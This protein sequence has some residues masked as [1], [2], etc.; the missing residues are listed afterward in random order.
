MKFAALNQK[1]L[2]DLWHVRGQA[3]AISLVLACGVGTYV[4][5]SGMLQS[6]IDTRQ[7]YYNDYRLADI[8]ATVKRAPNSILAKIRA[9]DGVRQV[10]G[11]VR[12]PGIVDLATVSAPISAQLLSI[13]TLNEQ[14]LN[15]IVLRQGRM[16]NARRSQEI[17]LL[18]AFAEAHKLQPGDALNVVLNGRKKRFEI[19]GIAIAPELVYAIAPGEIVPDPGRYGVLWLGHEALSRAFDMQGAFNEV[20]LLKNANT[21]SEQLIALLDDLLE[22]YGATGAIRRDQ[23]ISDQFLSN[24]MEQLRTMGRVLPPVFLLVAGFLLHVVLSR[25][26]DTQREQIGLLK[27]FGY[28]NVSLAM[29]FLGMTL[30]IALLGAILG[31]AMGAAL[32]RAMAVLYMQY[33]KFP[34]LHFQMPLGTLLFGLLGSLL[35]AWLATLVSIKRVASL[36][37]ATAMLPPAPPDYTTG[38]NH[39]R[40]TQL[41][42]SLDQPSRMILRHL[43]R[44]PRR[45]LMTVTGIALAMGLLVGSSFA[46]DASRYMVDISFNVIDRYDLN[47]S[48]FEPR[49]DQALFNLKRMPGVLHAEAWRA[50]PVTLING[51]QQRRQAIIGLDPDPQLSRIVDTRL[52]AVSLPRDGL[53]ISDKLAELLQVGLGDE[54]DV[55]VHEGRQ[56]QLT[57]PVTRIVEAFMGTTAVMR[58]TDLNRLLLSDRSSSGAYL[59][60]DNSKQATLYQNLK[61]TPAVAGLAIPAEAQRTFNQLMA[62]SLGSFVFFNSLFAGL[63]VVGVVYNAARV[64]LSE[65]GRE[66]ASL[67]VLGLTRAEVSWILLGELAILTLISLPIGAFLGYGLAWLFVQSLDT[68]LF[69]I[70]LIIKPATY[71]FAIIV[72]VTATAISSLI[73]RR[74][75]DRLDLVAVLKT[76]E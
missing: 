61:Q 50:V 21:S 19:V 39:D 53:A 72:V 12:A 29:H 73:V 7:A 17:V 68:E 45:A 9:L 8:S 44:W 38:R 63:I 11:R 52:Q 3:L 75:I 48:F 62:E 18:Q 22:P 4:M 59:M 56:P 66:L 55:K 6:L 51:S 23:Q 47:V 74:R 33:F 42:Q 36:T 13:D 64:S 43:R 32:G 58:R 70:P 67:R 60:I 54:L 16:P 40:G 57:I 46:L 24:E 35:I 30:S 2:R 1:M 26:I 20:I 76:R 14:R 27:A 25:L 71:G 41:L 49:S 31:L 15:N 34:F 37:P 5:S 69:S 65:R 10:E 28:G